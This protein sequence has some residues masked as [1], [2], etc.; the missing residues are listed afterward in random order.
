MRAV[1]F[2]NTTHIRCGDVHRPGMKGAPRLTHTLSFC[3]IT[4]L[5]SSVFPHY[6]FGMERRDLYGITTEPLPHG[7]RYS[8]TSTIISISTGIFIGNCCIP[9]AERACRPLI[10][11]EG[12]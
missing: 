4:L 11:I 6:C 8:C 3:V 10:A 2:S 9:T 5:K 12:D 7:S 1:V